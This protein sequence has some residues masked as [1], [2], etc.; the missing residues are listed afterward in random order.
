MP[1]G[2]FRTRCARPAGREE[3]L[4]VEVGVL[5]GF[6]EDLASETTRLVNRLRGVLL[7]TT[8]QLA[9]YAGLAPVTRQSGTSINSQRHD[10]RGNRRIKNVFFNA[11][12]SALILDPN[13]RSVCAGR[14]VIGTIASR[15][16]RTLISSSCPS[17]NGVAVSRSIRSKIPQ[18]APSSSLDGS[19]VKSRLMRV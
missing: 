9:A 17:S 7:H 13:S 2:R 12:H 4:Q 19:G 15:R 18:S 6:D 1:P 3:T 5:V 14:R 8:D 11:A 10:R 16:R